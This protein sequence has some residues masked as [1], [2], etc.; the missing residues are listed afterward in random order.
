MKKSIVFMVLLMLVLPYQGAFAASASTATVE[1]LYFENYKSKVKEVREAQKA[2]YASLCSE[3]PALTAKAKASAAQYNSLVKS[4]AGKEAAA[5]AKA[6]R[7]QDKKTLLSAKKTCMKKV[8]EAKKQSNLQLREVD[9]YKRNLTAMIKA[10][11][12]GKDRM[13]SD[14]FNKKVQEGLI[15]INDKLDNIIRELKAAR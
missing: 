2:L 11:L 10:H 13:K 5:Q 6:V 14:E 9:K 15:Y 8:N 7:D 3:L 1:K 12:A 4:K